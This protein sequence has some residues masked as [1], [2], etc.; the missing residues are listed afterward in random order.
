MFKNRD[1]Q[2]TYIDRVMGSNVV[3]ALSFSYISRLEK[4]RQNLQI[5][6]MGRFCKF[7]KS[8]TVNCNMQ[9]SVGQAGPIC[10]ESNHGIENRKLSCYRKVAYRSEGGL[11]RQEIVNLI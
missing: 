9:M 6:L 7:P 4:G 3:T 2:M 1:K 8:K 5:V 10:R 11:R